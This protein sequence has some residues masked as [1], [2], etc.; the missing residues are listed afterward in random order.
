M[1]TR[2]P[3]RRLAPLAVVALTLAAASLLLGA[4]RPGIVT[5]NAQQTFEGDISETEQ[6]VTIVRGGLRATIARDDVATIV[7]ATYAER[8]ARQLAELGAADVEG[9]VALARQAFDRREFVLASTAL[10]E[11]LAIDPL[12]REARRA[13]ALLGAQLQLEAKQTAR[14][15]TGAAEKAASPLPRVQKTK[16]LDDDQ[17]NLVRQAELCRGDHV[18][19]RFRNNVRKRYVETQPGLSYREF[20]TLP[21]VDQALA[22]LSHG[23]REMAADVD[24][25]SEP[26][27]IQSFTR[28]IQGAV[29]QGCATSYCHGGD[30]AGDF[31]LL[32]GVPDAST[33]ITNFYLLNAWS[34]ERPA[35]AGSPFSGG[36]MEMISRGRA[37]ESVLLQFALPRSQAKLK[38]P[39]V[40]GWDGIVRDRRDRLAVD[41]AEWIDRELS[42]IRP[43]YD[44][45]YSPR[46]ATTHPAEGVA[47]TQ[48]EATR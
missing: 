45:H 39:A 37:D 47:T 5:T 28:R 23:P 35:V 19:I 25:L 6:S 20:A 44:F 30:H 36:T 1:A 38:H 48:P 32:T 21:D 29:V 11:A 7:Y 27:A 15:A 22:I 42:P 2:H 26:A 3:V 14:A 46:A 41:I 24:V 13:S 9:R 18:R 16:G 34:K 4:G 12:D 31:K 8:F 10:D 40:R 43:S 33:A 17:V